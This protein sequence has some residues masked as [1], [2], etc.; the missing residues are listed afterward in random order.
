MW[1][2]SCHT[3]C[4]L[5]EPGVS[6]VRPVSRITSFWKP[7]TSKESQ[8]EVYLVLDPGP[9]CVSSCGP[10]RLHTHTDTYTHQPTVVK[11]LEWDPLPA[12]PPSSSV[13]FLPTVFW[14]WRFNSFN[15]LLS[16]SVAC[17]AQRFV[18]TPS[19]L[20]VYAVW[21]WK[22]CLNLKK[23]KEEKKRRKTRIP[24]ALCALQ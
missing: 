3:S 6:F 19:D 7:V 14:F 18:H 8:T 11:N 16:V 1:L 5:T 24:A 20:T 10:S 15:T 23:R 12:S 9:W 13:F 17:L 21:A 22:M 4:G 2:V